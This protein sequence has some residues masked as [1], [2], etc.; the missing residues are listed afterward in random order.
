MIFNR[1][2]YIGLGASIILLIL[3]FALM[4]GPKPVSPDDFNP[5]MFNFRRL[6]LAPII[7]LA[8]YG[9]LAYTILRKPKET[10]SG[11]K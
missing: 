9:F 8:S 2:K 5:D 4:S 1:S 11:E 6:T 10:C 7:V 3:G